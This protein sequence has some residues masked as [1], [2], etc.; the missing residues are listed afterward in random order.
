MKI[1]LLR[2]VAIL[3]CYYLENRSKLAK[4]MVILLILVLANRKS[5]GYDEYRALSTY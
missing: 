5:E 1:A 3:G 2:E 4:L